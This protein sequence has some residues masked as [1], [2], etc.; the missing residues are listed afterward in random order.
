MH[1]FY[2]WKKNDVVTLPAS[3]E[4]SDKKAI[5]KNIRFVID[6]CHY[7]HGTLQSPGRSNLFVSYYAYVLNK[8]NDGT[9]TIDDKTKYFI[10]TST[11][12]LD[13][14][15]NYYSEA[16]SKILMRF[17]DF[18]LKRH[19]FD[20]LEDNL[21]PK[22]Y[23]HNIFDPCNM[24][25]EELI[26][27][28][29]GKPARIKTQVSEFS[30]LPD[31]MFLSYIIMAHCGDI[32][33]K[34]HLDN[35]LANV[36]QTDCSSRNFRAVP[37]TQIGETSKSEPPIYNGHSAR[38]WYFI[39]RKI[40]GKLKRVHNQGLIHGNLTLKTIRIKYKNKGACPHQLVNIED[41]FFVDF[42]ESKS[43][44]ESMISSAVK[45]QIDDDSYHKAEQTVDIQSIGKILFYLACG[46]HWPEEIALHNDNRMPQKEEL[47]QIIS[48]NICPI[49]DGEQNRNE[50]LE[51]YV[52]YVSISKIID[53]CLRNPFDD[54]YLC[55]EDM[56]TEL[57]IFTK[58]M[59]ESTSDTPDSQN[60][61]PL[62]EL[63]YLLSPNLSNQNHKLFLAKSFSS[64]DE[65]DLAD[66]QAK[67]LYRELNIQQSVNAILKYSDYLLQAPWLSKEKRTELFTQ[68]QSGKELNHTSQGNRLRHTYFHGI[69]HDKLLRLRESLI[70]LCRTHYEI[71]GE[72]EILIPQLARIL[73]NLNHGDIYF[74]L[75]R[76]SYWTQHNLG[77]HGRFFSANQLTSIVKGVR[78][79][80]VFVLDNKHT[81][82]VE[83]EKILEYHAKFQQHVIEKNTIQYTS[84][85]GLQNAI[86][87]DNK[88]EP[89]TLKRIISHLDE[90]TTKSNPQEGANDTEKHTDNLKSMYIALTSNPQTISTVLGDNDIAYQ[91]SMHVAM[92]YSK[93]TKTVMTFS[94]FD[95]ANNRY[96]ND[97]QRTVHKARFTLA[98]WEDVKNQKSPNINT[99]VADEFVRSMNYH[100]SNSPR[101]LT[102]KLMKESLDQ[103]Y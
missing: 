70:D 71:E 32:D 34:Q 55:C 65:A 100:L 74:T 45:S 79:M 29:D 53:K 77:S 8:N 98:R 9:V 4:K 15:P 86:H 35:C 92:I 18:K 42:E 60:I 21:A 1:L 87:K 73:A 43:L 33:Y 40:I 80:R 99:V 89:L 47:Q 50:S 46:K 72:R 51:D 16:Y 36:K 91:D 61:H 58:C 90:N 103:I 12:P 30:K 41:V 69:Y 39:A 44:G 31:G 78:T 54:Q 10:K 22:I 49:G 95:H 24:K 59:N 27:T 93:T 14:P 101:D 67:D 52:R 76:P 64:P 48:N 11:L 37:V 56:E 97:R 81:T 57:D 20:K 84:F 83:T 5:E 3:L 68:Y 6:E 85:D 94:F 25:I 19:L 75:T 26:I 66:K 62:K 28:D 7:R 102:E 88:C 38:Q 23:A 63:A 96:H 82:R 17:N 13:C 2:Q